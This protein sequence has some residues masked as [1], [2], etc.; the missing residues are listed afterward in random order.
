VSIVRLGSSGTDALDKEWIAV[1][2]AD[3]RVHITYS[4][5]LNATSSAIEYQYAD[6][7]LSAWSAPRE[8]SLVS[9]R[10]WVQ[11][12]RPV[13]GEGSNLYVIYYLIGPVDVDYYR[14]AAS[15]NRGAS[16]NAS[17][18]TTVVSFYPNYGTGAPGFNRAMGIQF[19]SISIDKSGG[20][21]DGRLYVTFAE[22]LNWF[23]DQANVGMAGNT[24]EI[25]SN[26]SAAT[27]T[28]TAVGR[29]L[30]GSTSGSGSGTLDPDYYSMT[31]TAGQTV[32]AEVD[33]LGAGMNVWMRMLATDGTTQLAYL[34]ATTSD[35]SYGPSAWI[36]T[37]PS[38]GVY[39]LRVAGVS[40][41]GGYRVKTG[42]A[43]RTTERGQDQRDVF[44]TSS[45]NGTTWST[46]VRVD[47][48][49]VGFDGWL[50]EVAVAA[51]GQVA[52]AWY[53]WRDAT[54]T[55]CGGESNVYLATSD[56]GGATW[57]QAGAITDARTA[58]SST[59]T[60]I[61]PNQ[62]D[63]MSLD[64]SPEGLAIA[65]S[66]GRNGNPDVYYQF[67][68]S[69]RPF[70]TSASAVVG[71]VDLE[72]FMGRAPGTMAA[73]YRS[74]GS[75]PFDSIATL[76]LDANQHLTYSDTTGIVAGQAYRYELGVVTSGT[77]RFYPYVTVSIPPPGLRLSN[78]VPSPAHQDAT[79]S[80]TLP[81]SAPAKLTLLD[82]QGHRLY[83]FPVSGAGNHTVPI[84]QDK[85]IEAG[86]YFFKLE[87][88]GKKATKR[89]V[90]V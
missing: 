20:A 30:R 56:D 37:A 68:N 4:D 90:V 32:I 3:G 9:E 45:D 81:T 59:Q 17:G 79:I 52:C 39:Y 87:Q 31:L 88:A 43:T 24:Q 8:I 29:V 69:D 57:T 62:G 16:F 47:T 22:C 42:L 82:V 60:N 13:V 64:Q 34:T 19:P 58:W 38:T 55:T 85:R 50:P 35:L 33:S 67:M 83:S 15:T 76:V 54:P 25:E 77:E 5:F 65:W 10:G 84:R 49:P 28:P 86:V 74:V 75:A 7:A 89:I 53:D 48:A 11:G 21:H 66:D 36:Y 70:L 80:F 1:D 63:Y 71:R 72:W 12:S 2:P 6:S 51:D 27:A 41:S 46:P 23:D 61:A 73:L 40:G 18:P 44:V 78:P 26:N 14:I